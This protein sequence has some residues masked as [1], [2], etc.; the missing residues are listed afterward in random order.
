MTVSEASENQMKMVGLVNRLASKLIATG[1]YK[2]ILERLPQLQQTWPIKCT[3]EL[4]QFLANQLQEELSQLHK[5]SSTTK[6]TGL[7]KDYSRILLSVLTTVLQ[8]TFTSL[9]LETDAGQRA[10]NIVNHPPTFLECLS[11][12]SVLTSVNKWLDD[13]VTNDHERIRFE[14]QTFSERLIAAMSAF[15]RVHPFFAVKS[16]S[17]LFNDNQRV[18]WAQILEN[19]DFG[20]KEE[21]LE[22]SSD[23]LVRVRLMD[24]LLPGNCL[25][26]HFLYSTSRQIWNPDQVFFVDMARNLRP[27]LETVSH[28]PEEYLLTL[29]NWVIV[30]TDNSLTL[31]DSLAHKEN[32][33]SL[34]A[35]SEKLFPAGATFLAANKRCSVLEWHSKKVLWELSSTS[36]LQDSGISLLYDSACADPVLK[37]IS[38]SEV[39]G[40]GWN[41]EQSLSLAHSFARSCASAKKNSAFLRL[42][43]EQME[44]L[45]SEFFKSH[46]M[47]SSHSLGAA[48]MSVFSFVSGESEFFF[49]CFENPLLLGRNPIG[50][51]KQNFYFL[52][53]LLRSNPDAVRAAQLRN[54][55]APELEVCFPKDRLLLELAFLSIENPEQCGQMFESQI[56]NPLY[57]DILKQ[58]MGLFYRAYLGSLQI[59][60]SSESDNLMVEDDPKRNNLYDGS[61]DQKDLFRNQFIHQPNKDS[62]GNPIDGGNLLV[63]GLDP[64]NRPID[65]KFGALGM[66]DLRSGAVVDFESG[67]AGKSPDNLR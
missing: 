7:L 36:S 39:R 45:S 24:S 15:F 35:A 38:L 59:R 65:D 8:R 41:S 49:E 12:K 9:E 60:E 53:T 23:P 46:A 61:L 22:N 37:W 34:A 5:D 3:F 40:L 14:L 11:A 56:M 19:I 63:T 50:I 66:L 18:D 62:R 64:K 1:E 42:Q 52:L 17:G 28:L 55:F 6:L 16:A 33:S 48:L 54:H 26:F 2:Q 21:L 30:F 57:V 51:K 32:I 43:K 47:T 13:T 10:K 27:L 67:L 31:E 4:E 20:A 44:Q 58:K 25:I 29:E